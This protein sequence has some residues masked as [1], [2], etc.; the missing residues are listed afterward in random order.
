MKLSLQVRISDGVAIVACKG[1]I[2]YRNEVA[3]FS[4]TVADVLRQSRQVVLDL[5]EVESIDGAGLGELLALLALARVR[6]CT[7][8]LAA[9]S[10]SVRELLELTQV[11][12]AFEIYATLN[13]ALLEEQVHAQTA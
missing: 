1:R 10:K 4:C 6:D 2:V 8:R 11:A 5:S 9:P 3:A 12:S 7:L 13:D